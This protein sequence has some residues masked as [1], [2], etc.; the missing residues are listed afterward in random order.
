MHEQ[1]HRGEQRR[2]AKRCAVQVALQVPHETVRAPTELKSVQRKLAILVV[3][4]QDGFDEK[5]VTAP[6]AL[7]I[8]PRPRY[9]TERTGLLTNLHGAYRDEQRECEREQ[10]RALLRVMNFDSKFLTGFGSRFLINNYMLV[11]TLVRFQKPLV[12][13]LNQSTYSS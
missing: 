5:V 12:N 3:V 2:R 9:A 11:I 10:W 7:E 6:K 1:G 4:E 8:T 13:Q